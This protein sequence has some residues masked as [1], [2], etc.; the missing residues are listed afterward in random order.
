MERA[1]HR[2]RLLALGLLGAVGHLMTGCAVPRHS[3]V[4][5]TAPLRQVEKKV[6]PIPANWDGRILRVGDGAPM[7]GG[8]ASHTHSFAHR[9]SL[10]SGPS[11]TSERPLGLTSTGVSATHVHLIES[12]SQSVLQTGPAT[13]IPPSREL[14]GFIA[15]KSFRHVTSRMIVGFSGA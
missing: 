8:E 15:R 6:R 12:Q 13:N 14:L 3:L 7:T 1:Q 9:H 11:T 4:L 2:S 5:S 10:T